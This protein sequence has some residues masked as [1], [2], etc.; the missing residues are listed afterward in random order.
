MRPLEII[1]I[2]G[3]LL[4]F[5]GYIHLFFRNIPRFTAHISRF[6]TLMLVLH[7]TYL[8]LYTARMDHPPLFNVFEVFATLSFLI[9]IIYLG[10]ETIEKNKSTGAFFI[11]IVFVLLATSFGF[12]P[13]RSIP[14]KELSIFWYLHLLSFLASYSSLTVAAVQSNL[15]LML[16]HELKAHRFSFIY[17]RL[18]PLEVINNMNKRSLGLGFSLLTLGILFGFAQLY[19]IHHTLLLWEPKVLLMVFTW[20][21]YGICLFILK[22]TAWG[23]KRVAYFSLGGYALIFVSLIYINVI[24]SRFHFFPH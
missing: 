24:F 14:I 23:G 8:V 16:Y 21:I 18:P 17:R 20:F 15:Y 19:I 3:Y 10:V 11:F 1:L 12:N 5:I 6:L 4:L 22:R 7:L 13:Q 2:I 9:G